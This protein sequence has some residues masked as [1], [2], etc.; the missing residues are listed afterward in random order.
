TLS[1]RDT[2]CGIAP[3][4]RQHIF[5]P[6]QRLTS[7]DSQPGVGLGLAIVQQWVQRMNGRIHVDSEVGQGTTISVALPV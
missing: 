6:F 1:V 4:D 7:A 3:E 5:E 2:G